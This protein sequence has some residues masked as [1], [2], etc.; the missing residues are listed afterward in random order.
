M[1]VVGRGGGQESG[2]VWLA[3]GGGGTGGNPLPVWGVGGGIGVAGEPLTYPVLCVCLW[4]VCVRVP[5]IL[6]FLSLLIFALLLSPAVSLG[7]SRSS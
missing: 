4:C 6:G 3:A 7:A 1:G 5:L 2:S